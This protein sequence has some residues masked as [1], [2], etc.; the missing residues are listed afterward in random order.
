MDLEG[1]KEIEIKFKEKQPKNVRM[2]VLHGKMQ[3]FNSFDNPDRIRPQES[4]KWEIGK[5]CVKIQVPPR[6]VTLIEVE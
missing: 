5:A 2:R 4:R 6:S 1:E 3:D